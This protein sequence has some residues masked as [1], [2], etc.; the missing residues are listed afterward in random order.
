MLDNFVYQ[1]AICLE[2]FLHIFRRINNPEK[3]SAD[4]SYLTHQLQEVMDVASLLL[5]SS[6]QC[7]YNTIK[8]KLGNP[9]ILVVE[10]EQERCGTCPNCLGKK[11]FPSVSKDGMKTIL[12]DI[13]LLPF[14]KKIA[15]EKEKRRKLVE[16]KNNFNAVQLVK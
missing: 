6:G 12:F 5:S 10:G 15:N 8:K 11:T 16:T 9:Y 1:V 4:A 13:F 14:S 2:S 3:R 7:Y